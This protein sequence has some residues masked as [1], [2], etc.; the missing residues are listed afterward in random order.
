MMVGETLHQV[1][2]SDETATPAKDDFWVKA[3][4][5]RFTSQ[6]KE[7]V[8]SM[9][10]IDRDQRPRADELSIAVDRGMRIWRQDTEDGRRFIAKGEQVFGPSEQRKVT[11]LCSGTRGDAGLDTS[12]PE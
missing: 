7:I 6:L 10:R 11:T 2:L 8:R 5:K 9:L 1:D 3:L 4:P 12:G